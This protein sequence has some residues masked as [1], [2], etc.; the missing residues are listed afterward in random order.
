M[1]ASDKTAY[2]R[3]DIEGNVRQ[4]AADGTDSMRELADQITGAQA[5][6]KQLSSANRALKGTSEE[7]KAAKEK[8]SAAIDTERRQI[9]S[10]N[11]ALL[12]QGVTYERLVAEARAAEQAKVRAAQA[13]SLELQRLARAAD[14]ARAAEDRLARSQ[15]KDAA[16]AA[17]KAAKE[18]AD[19]ILRVE[20][21]AKAAATAQEKQAAATRDAVSRIGGPLSELVQQ[22][23]GLGTVAEGAGTGIGALT[24]AATATVAVVVA[25]TAAMVAAT[26]ALIGWIARS[27]DL[28]RSQQLVRE[29]MAGTAENAKNLGTQVALLASRVH[30]PTAE[31]NAMSTEL[32]NVNLNGA[33]A[34]DA[35]NAIGQAAGAAGPKVGAAIQEWITRGARW[36]RMSLNPLEMQSTGLKF[37]D[38]ATEYA[39]QTGKGIEKARIELVTGMAK[40]GPAAAA[41]RTVVERQYAAINARKMLELDNVTTTF[42]KH[43]QTLTTGVDFERIAK[44]LGEIMDMFDASTVN[45]A[46]LRDMVTAIGKAMGD[47]FEGGVPTIKDFI[48]D[49][50]IGALEVE[51]AFFKVR[52]ALRDSFAGPYLAQIDPVKTALYALGTVAWIAAGGVLTLAAATIEIW[53]PIVA[54]GMAVSGAIY[55]LTKLYS[56]VKDTNW[57]ALGNAIVDG[58]VGGIKRSA[59]RAADAVRDMMFG[60]NSAGKKALDAHSPS[61]VYEAMGDDTDE[62]YALGVTKNKGKASAAVSEMMAPPASSGKAAAGA[63]GGGGWVLHIHVDGGKHAQENVSA[64]SSPSFTSQLMHT[65]ESMAAAAGIPTQ[66]PVTP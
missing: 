13:E 52:N 19:A 51:I 10:A 11:V 23:R 37:Q 55:Y 44:P 59:H 56:W 6:V 46:A 41:L 32:L 26:S 5:V 61:R 27:S 18:Q 50:T 9:E 39:K 63:T 47:T 60:A 62:G 31:L 20:K 49:L 29:A 48:Q 8:L 3:V 66:A 64:L 43:L 2:F 42:S 38:V 58:F 57:S 1:G 35:M 7:V 21:A 53:G 54:I 16:E 28:N 65:I 33:E 30:T 36:Q 17:A 22:I 34:V 40:L 14:I 45:G 4:F 25:L 15:A 12:K 24:I